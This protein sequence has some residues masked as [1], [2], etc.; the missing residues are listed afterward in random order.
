MPKTII[1][2][3][4]GT[5][6]DIEPLFIRIFNELS[7]EFGYAPIA[8]E[9]LPALKKL[10]LKRLIFQRLGWRIIFFPKMLRRG[11]EEYFKLIQEVN[12]FPGIDTVI[13]TLRNEG[14][15]IGVVSSSEKATVLALLK[16]FGIE[17]DFVYQSSLFGKA[18]ILRTVF[19]EQAVP[20]EEAIYVGDEV[21]DV[22]A[23]KKVGLAVIAVTWGLNTKEALVETGVETVDTPEA[24]LERLRR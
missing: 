1:F 8:P 20:K 17:T 9:E 13:K 7:A 15:R 14:H 22:D 6:V 2:D 23:C 4:D 12:L 5:L 24:L 19:T 21:R 11:R 10:H 16:K 3:L 18:V